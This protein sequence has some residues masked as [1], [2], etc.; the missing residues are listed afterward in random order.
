MRWVGKAEGET[1]L[2]VRLVASWL[3]VRIQCRDAGR[4]GAARYCNR[5]AGMGARAWAP[6]RSPPAINDLAQKGQRAFRCLALGADSL[7]V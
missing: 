2:G 5:V 1:G 4:C 6:G 3:A 7:I